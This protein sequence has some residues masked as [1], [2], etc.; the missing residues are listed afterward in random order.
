MVIELERWE[1]NKHYER[2]GLDTQ[3]SEI[4]EVSIPKVTIPVSPG[5]NLSIIIETAARNFREKVM[6]YNPANEFLERL[7]DNPLLNEDF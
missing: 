3:Y 4:I 2:L 5:R 7:K 6:G 1:E